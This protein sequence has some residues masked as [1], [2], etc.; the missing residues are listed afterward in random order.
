MKDTTE[1]ELRK[2]IANEKTKTIIIDG[3]KRYLSKKIINEVKEREKEGGI[4]P[5]IPIIAGILGATTAAAGT[6]AGIAKTVSDSREAQKKSIEIEK[7]QEELKQLKEKNKPLQQN[8][9]KNGSG[10]ILS[11]QQGRGLNDFFKNLIKQDGGNDNLIKVLKSF[12]NG[13]KCKIYKDGKGIYL[14]KF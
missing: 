6:A 10:F 2:L 12:K 11:P 13:C 4:L 1:E 3:K 7:A 9:A 14:K 8:D 5:L